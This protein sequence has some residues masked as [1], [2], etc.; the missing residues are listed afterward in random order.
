MRGYSFGP[1][2]LIPSRFVLMCNEVPNPLTPRLISVLR[3]LIENRDRVVTKDEMISRIW[4][5]SPID[6]GTVGRAVSTLRTVLSDESRSPQYIRTISR[7]GYRFIH[8]VTIVGPDVAIP[9][10]LGKLF[11]DSAWRGS[12]VGRE[13]EL[14]IV[15]ESLKRCEQ[16]MGGFICIS[17][18]A[19]V[20]KTALLEKIVLEAHGRFFVAKGQCA[21]HLSD[22][23]RY[24]AFLDAFPELFSTSTALGS[25]RN[26]LAA[27]ISEI[28]ARKPVLICIEDI[29]WADAASVDLISYMS[30]KIARCRLLFLITFRAADLVRS[31]HPFRHINHALQAR[32]VCRQL[33][34]SLLTLRETAR[35]ISSNFS[36]DA[37]DHLLREVYEN[38]EGNPFFISAL[39][40][41][42][43]HSALDGSSIGIPRILED[44]LAVRIENL[45]PADRSLLEIGSLQGAEFDSTMLAEVAGKPIEEVEERLHAV[46]QTHELIRHLGQNEHPGDIAFQK[47]VFVHRLYR[48]ILADLAAPSRLAYLKSQIEAAEKGR[49]GSPGG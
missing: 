7:V 20:G 2:T 28:S 47:Y 1:F 26:L 8:N 24:S 22:A 25:M 49:T 43:R 41:E 6:P 48:K 38:T 36:A 13:M 14:E 12:F 32:G 9:S 29:Q 11:P 40:G 23:A 31:N 15:R 37:P 44:F 4:R 45:D 5:D 30:T 17:G 27:T 35:Y 33:Q 39:F 34:L 18:E 21:P 16:G 19:G 10:S 3:Y 46:E 42:L